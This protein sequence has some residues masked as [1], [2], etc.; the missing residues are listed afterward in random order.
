MNVGLNMKILVVVA[1]L[2]VGGITTSA[3]NFSNEMIERGHEVTFLDLSGTVEEKDLPN[4]EIKI[5]RLNGKAK[6]WNITAKNSNGLSPILHKMLGLV[7][8]I[9]VRM[10]LWYKMI[11]TKFCPQEEFDVAIA[12]RQCEP[13]YAFVLDCVNAKK[14]IGFVHGELKY[15]GDISSWKKYM[16]RFTK[17]AYV[18]NAVKEQFVSAYPELSANAAVIYNMFNVEQIKKLAD[19][20]PTVE[21]DKTQKN[22]VTVC[23]IDN[24]FKRTNWI[25]EICEKLKKEVST[26]FHW[27]V[28]G[29]GVDYDNMVKLVKEK[30]V[31]DVLTFAGNQNNPYAIVKN[32][33]FSVL[34]SKSE[35][36]GLVVVEAF[37]LGVPILVTE[38]PA[39]YEIIEENKNGIIAKQDFD[40]LYNKVKMMIDDE[41]EI[42]SIC[43]NTLSVYLY[44][45]EKAYLQFLDALND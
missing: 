35:S 24:A 22:I 42:F 19:E 41:K 37:I 7:K 31:E 40:D 29:D 45:N 33:D 3:F 34:P 2:I 10:G 1:D 16:P 27:Y 15:M 17:I 43:T 38:Y 5:A 14:K 18:S 30:G 4:P 32:A 6:Y 28:L 25:V 11:F 21:F 36:F 9:T 20:K 13:C 23:R 39:A 12:F 26:S 8:K 44:N